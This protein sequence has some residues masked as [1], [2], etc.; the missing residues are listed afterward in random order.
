MWC[1]KSVRGSPTL[2]LVDGALRGPEVDGAGRRHV[3]G[4]GFAVKTGTLA[5]HTQAA[6]AGAYDLYDELLAVYTDLHGD[7]VLR[8]LLG[9]L[10]F[11]Q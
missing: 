9:Q 6:L 7:P 1:N 4:L 10:W 3:E 8:Q 2:H 11:I 5:G